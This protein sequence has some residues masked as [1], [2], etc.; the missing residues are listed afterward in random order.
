MYVCLSHLPRRAQQALWVFCLASL[1]AS[2]AC[3]KNEIDTSVEGAGD[4][5]VRS[6]THR[7][8]EAPLSQAEL[9]EA[10]PGLNGGSVCS[11][12]ADCDSPLRCITGE[13]R[14]P[15]AMTGER[16]DH[17][18]YV[19][20]YTQEAELRYDLELAQTLAE[21]R[22]GLMDRRHMAPDFGMLFVY[23]RAKPQSFWM[24]NTLIS[25]DII[26]I[27]A[28]G[29][30]DSIVEN[31]EPNSLT[32]RSSKG[33]AKYVLELVG[34]EAQRAGIRRGDQVEFTKVP[35]HVRP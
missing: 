15:R 17:T 20:I 34:G 27:Q 32:P 8:A 1:F 30:I 5:P 4:T 23:D 18:P 25:L 11:N 35:G 29:R 26:F 6:A 7:A 33:P 10:Y 14:F 31:A 12:D 9:R 24:K 19:A 3:T 16:S 13:C 2:V 28:D 22:R 21:Q